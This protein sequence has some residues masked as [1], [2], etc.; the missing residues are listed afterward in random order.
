MR[1]F[2]RVCNTDLL[3]IAASFLL[4]EKKGR[5]VCAWWFVMAR[6]YTIFLV[7]K[8]AHRTHTHSHKHPSTEQ[9]HW[10]WIV[11]SFF[12]LF[13]VTMP[14]CATIWLRARLRYNGMTFI[15]KLICG[16]DV[17]GGAEKLFNRQMKCVICDSLIVTWHSNDKR[18]LHVVA[19][20]SYVSVCAVKIP[21]NG[22][23]VAQKWSEYF[24]RSLYHLV[25]L[26]KF[27][28]SMDSQ[29]SEPHL[30][31]NHFCKRAR[32]PSSAWMQYIWKWVCLLHYLV[33]DNVHSRSERSQLNSGVSNLMI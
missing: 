18:M 5:D 31:I 28:S 29:P 13:K 22:Q 4:V 25:L 14:L 23:H 3:K 7:P 10:Q 9:V 21:S 1:T 12:S 33:N 24:L 8:H 32:V 17:C 26:A 27:T 16:W 19:R 30:Y 11:V 20:W 15:I 2:Y 6:D